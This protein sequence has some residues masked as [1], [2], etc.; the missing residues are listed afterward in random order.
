VLGLPR[1][2]ALVVR[3]E[4]ADPSLDAAVAQTRALLDRVRQGAIDDADRSRVAATLTRLHA[5]ADL[6]PRTRAIELWRGRTASPG[7]SLEKMRAFAA[8]AIRDEALVIVAARPPRAD[9]RGHLYP[10]RETRTKSRD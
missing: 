4:A 6:D 8:A 7:P 1:A 3:I 9:P 2:P 5:M 10:G